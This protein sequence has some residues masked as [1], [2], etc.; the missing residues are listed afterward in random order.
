LLEVTSESFPMDFVYLAL[1]LALFA[2]SLGFVQLC[3]RVR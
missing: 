2:G 1:V 3:E